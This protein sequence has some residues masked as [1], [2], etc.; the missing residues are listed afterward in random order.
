MS[1]Q[2]ENFCPTCAIIPLALAGAG[3][4]AVGA[5]E[6]EQKK[7]KKKML[8]LSGLCIL[9]TALIIVAVYAFN[10]PKNRY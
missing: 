2:R 4:S 10:K 3:M 1:E 9:S 5:T 6:S 7:H 8:L